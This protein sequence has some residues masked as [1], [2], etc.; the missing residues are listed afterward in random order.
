MKL[1]VEMMVLYFGRLAEV[2][3]ASAHGPQ[4]I[5]ELIDEGG[6]IHSY[7]VESHYDLRPL[8]LP[9][10]CVLDA[11]RR[12]TSTELSGLDSRRRIAE[13]WLANPQVGDVFNGDNAHALELVE[14]RDDGGITAHQN[15]TYGSRKARKSRR[16]ISYVNA[17]QLRQVLSLLT[18]PVYSVRAWTSSRPEFKDNP[19]L[20]RGEDSPLNPG[21]AL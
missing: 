11:V 20:Y 6:L 2:I 4:S 8:T 14:I 12:A 19:Y 15:Q 21:S 17:Q 1:E 18:N 5:V 9:G 7:I 3:F 13:Q 10:E 16:K